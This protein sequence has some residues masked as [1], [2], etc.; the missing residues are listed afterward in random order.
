MKLIVFQIFLA[1]LCALYATR[2]QAA[3]VTVK[4]ATVIFEVQT[5]KKVFFQPESDTVTGYEEVK[6]GSTRMFPL[7]EPTYYYYVD[8]KS[9]FH[10]VFL[11]PGSTTHIIERGGQV[12]F[13]GDNAD[14]NRYMQ[15]YPTLVVV[16]ANI[17]AY[18]AEWVEYQRK[19]MERKVETLQ[20][21]NLP[22]EF[23]RLHSLYYRS[24]YLLQL[25]VSPET[26]RVFQK[27]Q[28]ELPS[29][30][31]DDV[32][33]N[34]YDEAD[35]LNY[36]KWF[37]LMRKDL[38]LREQEGIIHPDYRNFITRYAECIE[39]DEVKGAFM[40]RYLELILKAG[41]AEDFLSYLKQAEEAV[42]QPTVGYLSQLDGLKKQYADLRG[43]VKNIIRG[44]AVPMFTGVDV[45]GN[46]HSS[47]DYS[48]KVWV[49]DF[50]FSGCIPCKAEMPY[51][52]KL[53]EEFK[54]KDIQF[55]SLS[56]DSG[57]QLLKAWTEL[58]KGK[59]GAELQLNIPEGFKSEL[60]R[61]F[62][63]RSV[64]RIIIVDKDGKV[65][66]AFARRPSDPKLRQLLKEMLGLPDDLALTKEEATRTMVSLSHA[67]TAD[68]KEKIMKKFVERVRHEKADFA[69]PMA[70]MM[71]SL[72]VEA[73]YMEGQKEKADRYMTMFSESPFKRDIY[74]MA[75]ARCMENNDWG[76]AEELL[77]KAARM[78]LDLNGNKEPDKE[79]KDKYALVFG[80]YSD[81]LVRNGHVAEAGPYVRLAYKY[82]ADKDYRLKNDYAA[83]LVF[84]KK[85]EEASLV[86][87]ELIKNGTGNAQ[88]E[89]WLEECYVTRR[90]S[91]KGFDKYLG[92]L[93]K[94]AAT[95]RRDELEQQM[96]NAPAPLFELKGLK[97]ETC[98]L[99]SLKGKVV[100][101][102][103]WATWCGP[104][105]ASFPA[106]KKAADYFAGDKD[107]VF[108]F[109][110]TL[111][112]K[113]NLTETVARYMTD[114]HYD[115]KVLFD[116]QDPITKKYPVINSYGAKGIPAKYIIDK[117]GNV[118]FKVVGFSGSEEETVEELKTMIGILK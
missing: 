62:G 117:N 38:E 4:N 51:M 11:T 115:F 108:L 48:G 111:E 83:V 98:S 67:E 16:P 97:G 23:V 34:C 95:Q 102:D 94:T 37:T 41:Y 43:K 103:F 59:K 42:K 9:K 77:G 71:I 17:V 82:S 32:F 39:N 68:E 80:F 15:Q 104:C 90:G 13:E 92:S 93:Q 66:D 25:L 64:P 65:F 1:V 57:N 118:R 3:T 114:N 84:E 26:V 69:Y 46:S 106:M 107:V 56:L 47:A 105:K 14:I 99:A 91:S 81:V 110:N 70:N 8:G 40:L 30:Y 85:Y 19:E 22:E 55:F 12:T 20:A 116:T 5:D 76:M 21:S 73:L 2:M 109:I 89:I 49:L 113:K 50:W 24:S 27:Q 33:A 52:E 10:T 6:P 53:A 7:E 87:E 35:L 79:E 58:V 18:S 31:Y 86:L 74:F 44:N 112:N 75:G 101:L 72:T 28:V 78:T 63:I 54:G 60:A 45:N 29:G 36:P 100:V 88:H 96:I 61:Y